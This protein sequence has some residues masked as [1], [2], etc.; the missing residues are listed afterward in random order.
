MSLDKL[1]V[2]WFI[3]GYFLFK[4]NIMYSLYILANIDFISL[5]TNVFLFKQIKMNIVAVP[6]N[7]WIIRKTMFRFSR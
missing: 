2:K 5:R 4:K 3:I 6:F 1:I 7:I